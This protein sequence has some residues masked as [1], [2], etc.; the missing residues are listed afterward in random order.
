M[1]FLTTCRCMLVH[2]WFKVRKGN[3]WIHRTLSLSRCL[4]LSPFP[5]SNISYPSLPIHNNH[6]GRSLIFYPTG[7]TSKKNISLLLVRPGWMLPEELSIWIGGKNFSFTFFQAIQKWKIK[8]KKK[9]QIETYLEKKNNKKKDRQTYR[10]DNLT[11]A[12]Y[13]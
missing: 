3:E 5:I 4:S 6:I 12:F 13:L 1:K 9:I 11:C 7:V 8:V 10:D 2:Q